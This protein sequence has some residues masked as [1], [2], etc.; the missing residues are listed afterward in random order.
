MSLVS[1]FLE[2]SGTHLSTLENFTLCI[3]FIFYLWHLNL[4]L[5]SFVFSF[6]FKLCNFLALIYDICLYL[7]M[8][9]VF[10]DIFSIINIS[11]MQL[12]FYH[13]HHQPKY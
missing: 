2:T 12:K 5:F 13:G 1:N 8:G 11:F 9:H 4:I 3:F 7:A 10:Y 6:L